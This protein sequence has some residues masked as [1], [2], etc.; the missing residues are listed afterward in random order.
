MKTVEM[1]PA[2][3]GARVVATAAPLSSSAGIFAA[4]APQKLDVELR[5]SVLS[6]CGSGDFDSALRIVDKALRENLLN[7]T[8]HFCRAMIL[9]YRGDAA[10][11]VL[12]SLNQTIRLN[13]TLV[14]ALKARAFI[15]EAKGD[16][17]SVLKDL[18]TL[19]ELENERSTV[20]RRI[21]IHLA[22]QDYSGLVADYSL[23][24][25]TDP[26]NPAGYFSRG[27]AYLQ[28]GEKENASADLKTA[29]RLFARQGA[30]SRARVA[31]NEATNLAK[32]A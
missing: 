13:P 22:Q 31:R 9:F 14:E 5:S 11:R 8:A 25:E 29:E 2:V 30:A 12:D 28:A 1:F 21:T 19:I 24:I 3:L 27:L 20:E 32:T 26:E 15:N 18:D 7:S 17:Q 4:Y 23:I 10:D 16:W 6:M